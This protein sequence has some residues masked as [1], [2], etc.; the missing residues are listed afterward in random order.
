MN[1]S[2]CKVCLRRILGKEGK[3]ITKNRARFTCARQDSFWCVFSG[4]RSGVNEDF[5]N[6]RCYGGYVGN[7]RLFGTTYR[8]HLQGSPLRMVPIGCPETSVTNYGRTLRNIA[9]ER[10]SSVWCT[11]KP[12]DTWHQS[13]TC[14][15]SVVTRHVPNDWGIGYR[16]LAPPNVSAH[17]LDW[18][19]GSS[20]FP[21]QWYRTSS[22]DVKRPGREAKSP[23]FSAEI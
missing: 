14:G 13:S 1:E 6:Q 12:A 5:S 19:L 9:E 11:V 8:P 23:T 7:Y 2:T 16:F 15:I 20:Q 18:V 21:T 10:R 4:C 22:P 3:E 17:S